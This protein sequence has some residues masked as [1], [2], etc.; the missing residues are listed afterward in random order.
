MCT[1][2]KAICPGHWLYADWLIWVF[3]HLIF[4][5]LYGVQ[6]LTPVR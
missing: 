1:Y 3:W 2:L 5:I 4:G 6:I